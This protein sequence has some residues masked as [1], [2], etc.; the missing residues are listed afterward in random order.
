MDRVR[1]SGLLVNPLM[2]GLF[3]NLRQQF[4]GESPTIR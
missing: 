2:P 4:A 3:F 1:D